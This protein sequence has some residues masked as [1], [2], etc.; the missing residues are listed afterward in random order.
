MAVHPQCCPQGT[1]RTCR[2]S[3]ACSGTCLQVLSASQE[4]KLAH[5]TS[6]HPSACAA[7]CMEVRCQ[8]AGL[9]LPW[10][11]PAAPKVPRAAQAPKARIL[12]ARML[13]MTDIGTAE[14]QDSPLCAMYPGSR[15]PCFRRPITCTCSCR[16]SCRPVKPA[17]WFK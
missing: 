16:R 13:T 11:L 3:D 12:K 7:L 4:A 10:L 6:L 5:L 9:K 17:P 14:V 2:G 8:K 1:A 15:L